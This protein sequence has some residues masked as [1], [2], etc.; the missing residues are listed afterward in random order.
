MACQAGPSAWALENEICIMERNESV[1]ACKNYYSDV[2]DGN[3]GRFQTFHALLTFCLF[4]GYVVFYY[5]LLDGEE[6]E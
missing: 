5:L 3:V 4:V 1:E 2:F 6:L